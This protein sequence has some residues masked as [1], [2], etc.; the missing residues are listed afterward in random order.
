MLRLSGGDPPVEVPRGTV[1]G[2]G[3]LKPGHVKMVVDDEW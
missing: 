2:S 3:A 1:Q